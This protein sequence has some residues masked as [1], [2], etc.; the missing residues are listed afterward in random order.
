MSVSCIHDITETDPP[1][2][3][4]LLSCEHRR[5]T[6]FI[7]RFR[8][9]T[10]CYLSNQ[11]SVHDLQFAVDCPLCPGLGLCLFSGLDCCNPRGQKLASSPC[12]TK[13]TRRASRGTLTLAL[14]VLVLCGLLFIKGKGSLPLLLRCYFEDSTWNTLICHP[15]F[16]FNPPLKEFN[17]RVRCWRFYSTLKIASFQ[18]RSLS[19]IVLARARISTLLCTIAS[20]LLRSLTIHS[21]I[22]TTF[23]R[24]TSD[25]A[26]LPAFHRSITPLINQT[27]PSLRRIRIHTFCDIL[28]ILHSTLK[29]SRVTLIERSR[30]TLI[31]SLLC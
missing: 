31:S 17:G 6:P 30:P 27:R 23:E 8:A 29:P 28:L 16:H 21:Q 18:Y 13:A 19:F 5:Q 2:A 3:L 26:Q 9:N 7:T 25:S 14:L 11:D 12:S 22:D 20:S 10:V 15:P 4:V 1:F 24:H